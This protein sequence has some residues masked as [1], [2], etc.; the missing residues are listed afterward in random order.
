MYPP[1]DATS[2]S[3]GGKG[4]EALQEVVNRRWEGS[5]IP[6]SILEAG[7]LFSNRVRM[8]RATRQLWDERERFLKFERGWE[9]DDEDDEIEDLD[10]NELTLEEKELLKEVKAD[11]NRVPKPPEN[12]VDFGPR[13]DDLSQRDRQR[14]ES[15]ENFYVRIQAIM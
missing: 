5:D 4:M 15:V 9:T 11:E 14:L 13:A 10:L 7:E 8:T 2:N 3:A 1:L 12:P 6:A